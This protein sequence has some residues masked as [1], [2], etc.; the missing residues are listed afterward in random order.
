MGLHVLNSTPFIEI[1]IGPNGCASFSHENNDLTLLSEK[2]GNALGL[3]KKPWPHCLPLTGHS[4]SYWISLEAS[5]FNLFSPSPLEA[6]FQHALNQ[7]IEYLFYGGTFNP[8]HEGHSSCLKLAPKNLPLIIIPDRNPH[9][10]QSTY[11][12]SA[13]ILKQIPTD[14]KIFLYPGFLLSQKPNPTVNW[15]Q[16]IKLQN[17]QKNLSLLLGFDNLKSFSDWTEVEKLAG[18]LTCLYVVSR[19]EN[20]AEQKA[21]SAEFGT[22]FP[23]LTIHFL[24]HH[25]TE[26]LSSSEIRQKKRET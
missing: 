19:L 7:N 14:A 1:W 8:W 26:H 16:Q 12:A 2:E 4:E 15:A 3:I 17:P 23:K 22:R 20:E 13:D 24:G 5:R 25:S 9:K 18:L 21:L 10:D 6:K 11:P